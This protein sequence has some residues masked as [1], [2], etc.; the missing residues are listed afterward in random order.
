MATLSAALKKHGAYAFLRY[1][2]LPIAPPL[3]ITDDQI[4]ETIAIV[5]TAVSELAD[6]VTAQR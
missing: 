6:A 4:D 2:I 5:D 1:N 3:I